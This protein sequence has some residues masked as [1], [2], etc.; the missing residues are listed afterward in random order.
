MSFLGRQ[1]APVSPVHV[2]AGPPSRDSGPLFYQRFLA[3][4]FRPHLVFSDGTL[5]VV[6]EL[7][8]SV[9]ILRG[10]VL[11]TAS[12]FSETRDSSRA[13]R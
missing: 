2:N 1:T 12:V 10:E 13:L 3:P 4:L 11:R 8:E 9:L 6:G 7:P 5:R